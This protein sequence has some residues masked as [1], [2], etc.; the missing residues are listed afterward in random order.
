VLQIRA[1]GTARTATAR[2]RTYSMLPYLAVGA[3]DA[4]LVELTV[5]AD[6]QLPVVIG[7]V[8]ATGIVAAR[9][10]LALRDNATL[11]ASLQE[12]QRL[13]RWQATHDTLTG[14]ANR[15]LFHEQLA[16]AIATPGPLTA[17][18]IDLDDFKTVNDTLGHSVGDALLLQVGHRLRSAVRPGDL[19]ARLGGDE[20]AVLLPGTDVGGGAEVAARILAALVSPIHAQGHPLMAGASVG[21]A[22]W[23][24]RDDLETLLRHADV[25]MYAAKRSGKNR[26]ARYGPDLDGPLPSSL[27]SAD[28]GHGCVVAAGAGAFVA[29]PDH[30]RID[31]P[32]VGEVAAGTV[33]HV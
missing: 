11:V 26:F 8:A 33:H 24:T 22:E 3:I 32:G 6:S 1:A 12:H 31:A 5:R 19:V 15:V 17:L 4:L 21:V 25:A 13:L 2:R 20:F 16:T 10:L 28:A 9:Q 7:A 23:N 29:E 30:E 27:K 18:L 14:L